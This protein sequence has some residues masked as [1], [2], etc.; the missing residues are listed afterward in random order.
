MGVCV[1]GIQGGYMVTWF[2]CVC[3]C[4][5][6]C[7]SV[8]ALARE[9]LLQSPDVESGVCVDVCVCVCVCVCACACVRARVFARVWMH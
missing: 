4:G 9:D 8:R 7:V 5:C 1:Q 2:T 6:E 3:V